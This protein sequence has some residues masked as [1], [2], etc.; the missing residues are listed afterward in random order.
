MDLPCSILAHNL[1]QDFQL[2]SLR[3]HPDL[4]VADVAAATS[5]APTYFPQLKLNQIGMWWCGFN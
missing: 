2:S 3:E 1:I 5:A 4:F